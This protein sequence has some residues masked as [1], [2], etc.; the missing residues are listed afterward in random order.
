VNL[1]GKS[2][3]KY[4]ITDRLGQ[5]GM[6]TVFRGVQPTIER[7]VAVKVLHSHLAMSPGFV[8]RFKREARGLGQ[9]HHPHIVQVIDFDVQDDLYYMVM[10]YIPGKTLSK[11]LDERG[12][13]PPIEAVAIAE[14]LTTA[15]AYA[16]RRGII[17]RD[18]KPSNVL[19]RDEAC[20]EAVL[21]DFGIGKLVDDATMTMSG[22]V[23]GTPAY[24]SP[25]AAMGLRVDARADLYSM[26][27]ILYEMVTGNV[28]YSGDTPMSV[29]MKQANEPLPSLREHPA[30]LPEPLVRVIERS[31]EKDVANRYQSAEELLADLRTACLNLGGAAPAIGATMAMARPATAVDLTP[32][33]SYTAAPAAAPTPAPVAPPAAAPGPER[34]QR[35]PIF[36]GAGALVLLLLVGVWF[37]S[38]RG[39]DTPAAAPTAAPTTA[40]AV[41]ATEGAAAPAPTAASVATAAPAANP[42]PSVPPTA[43]PAAPP[44]PPAAG[45]LEFAD[46]PDLP[47]GR[48]LVRLSRVPLPPAGSQYHLWLQRGDDAP[49]DAGALTVETG[50]ILSTGDLEEGLLAPGSRALVTLEAAGE[51]PDAPSAD[52]VYAGALGPE[53]GQALSR[54]LV[55][56][57]NEVARMAGAREQALVAADHARFALESLAGDD[58]TMAQRH[59][60]HVVNI[61]DGTTG[62]LF[63][64][65]NGDG[66]AENP[67][68]NVGVRRYLLEAHE[69]IETVLAAGGLSAEQQ[70]QAESTLAAIDSSLGLVGETMGSAVALIATDS[71]EEAQPFSATM[72]AQMAR[73][74]GSASD[75]GLLAE[76]SSSALSLAAIP[77]TAEGLELAPPEPASAVPGRVGTLSFAGG[78]AGRAGDITLE[79]AQIGAPPEGFHYDAWLVGAATPLLLGELAVFN[80]FASLSGSFAMDDLSAYERVVITLDPDD[81]P[82]AQPGDTVVYEGAIPTGQ[83]RLV[84]QLLGTTAQA[85]PLF[86]ADEQTT[87]AEQHL[88]FAR[89]SYAAGDLAM[90]QRHMEHVVNILDGADGAFFGDLNFD[91]VAENPGDNIGTRGHLLRVVDQVT[92]LQESGDLGEGN[93]RFYSDQLMRAAALTKLTIEATMDRAKKVTS[94]D[95]LAEAST[96]IE[97]TGILLG[98]VRSGR[99]SD[100]NGV[101]DLLQGEGGL[102][103][104]AALAV[105]VDEVDIFPVGTAAA[106]SRPFLSLALPVPAHRTLA[107]G[108]SAFF[109]EFTGPPGKPAAVAASD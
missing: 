9:L 59:S 104:V 71:I 39:G 62:E 38:T 76:A 13:L 24:M 79:L 47:A 23:I 10:D 19:F 50:R 46:S 100:G 61:L 108:R 88:Q 33:A 102:V 70:A 55:S 3:G 65:L 94:S 85:G 91:G 74:L 90:A 51:T 53:L 14:Q 17:H 2:L 60:E 99:D 95:T 4:Q 35:W 69:Q 87:V 72:S 25:E 67:G 15:L 49:F 103:G 32:Q 7:Q 93:R 20:T 77:L 86:S 30:D 54:I 57:T 83:D 106:E 37:L 31:L 29:I 11:F 92:A 45:A 1:I 8:D 101:A 109:C 73:L 41:V 21:T 107:T 40:A 34:T 82:N 44:P 98:Q 28:P 6:A 16:H 48:F 78:G 75:E 66:Q 89:E 27:I 63:G 80:R 12:A 36:A 97:E 42:L 84:A 5:G 68:D 56:S 96:F 26:G 81:T 43:I 105:A 22:S 64:D 18:V 52:V 58:L